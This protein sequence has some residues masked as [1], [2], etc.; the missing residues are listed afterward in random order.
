VSAAEPT[1]SYG[2]DDARATSMRD[3]LCGNLSVA[4]VGRTVRL[5]GWVAR[6]REHGEH[7]AFVDLRDYSGIVQCVLDGSDDVRSEYVIAVEGMVRHRPE[8]TVNPR[9]STGEIELGDCRVEILAEAQP[10]PFAVEDDTEADE[11]IRLRHRFIDLRRPR[12]QANLRL[13]ATVNSALRRSME[14]QGFCEVETPLLW[15]PTPEGAREFAVPSRIQRGSFYVLPQS[16]QLAKQLLMVGGLDRYYQIAHCMRDEDLRADRQFEFTQFD[17]EASF[18]T[19]DDVLGFMTEAM[20]EVTEAVRGERPGPFDTITWFDA[21][22]RYGTDKPDLRFGMELVELTP[23]FAATGVRAFSAA[24]VKA[25]VLAGGADLPR[26]RLDALVERAG[27]L[28]AKGLA[29]LKVTTA[30]GALALESPLAR[31]LSAEE[32]GGLLAATG[33]AAGD[34]VLVVADDEHALA[35]RVL[36]ALRVELGGTPVG[37]GPLHYVWVVDFPLFEGLDDAGAPIP[38][39]HPFTMPHPDDLEKLTSDPL[40]VRSQSYDLVLNGWELGSGSIRIHRADIQAQVFRALGIAEETAATRF[41]F[42]LSA[43]R[44]GAPPHGGFAIGIDRLVAILAREEN[45]REVI[46]FPKTQSGSDP[47]TGAPA[48]LTPESLAELG[49]RIVGP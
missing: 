18:V 39:H 8:G 47:L 11:L 17:L 49:I 38:A 23:V 14:Q 40:S 3:G 4:D 27:V 1:P 24:C 30:E 36:G 44:F 21:L 25:I 20:A 35:C 45:I 10:P 33:A 43:F 2:T 41:G 16:P 48:A 32:Q 42:L 13:R 15:A 9:L 5:C 26:S 31:H 28:G 29:W 34:L 46:A 6:R 37:E 7:L 12:M 22:D 19:R